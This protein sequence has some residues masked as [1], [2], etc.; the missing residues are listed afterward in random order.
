MANKEVKIFVE[1]K[2][3]KEFIEAL[4]LLWKL[5]TTT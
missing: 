3:D 4:L 5:K 2:S 1:G